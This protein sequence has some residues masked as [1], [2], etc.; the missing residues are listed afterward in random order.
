VSTGFE[1]HCL[2]PWP[3]LYLN[4]FPRVNY[5]KLIDGIF[6]VLFT[7]ITLWAVV[8][9]VELHRT[10]KAKQTDLATKQRRL[11]ADEARLR[12]QLEY[13]DRLQHDRVLVEQLIREKLRYAKGDEFVFRFE[14]K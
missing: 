12:Q 14:E 10:L 3:H 13:L 5:G 4:P 11:T 7:A 8:Y 2:S 1:K 9:F 6:A